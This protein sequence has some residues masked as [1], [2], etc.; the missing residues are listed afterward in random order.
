MPPYGTWLRFIFAVNRG[1]EPAIAMER[2]MRPVEYRPEFR[3]D[4]AAVRTTR[5]MTSPAPWTPIFDRTVTKGLS[6]AE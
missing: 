1:A 5:F 6:S 4:M 3:D 2:R